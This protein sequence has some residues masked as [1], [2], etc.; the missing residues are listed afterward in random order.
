MMPDWGVE[1]QNST[2]WWVEYQAV[3]WWVEESTTHMQ[4]VRCCFTWSERRWR[5][6]VV[7]VDCHCYT[8]KSES[9]KTPDPAPD[10]K[11][12]PGQCLHLLKSLYGLKQAP[13]NWHLHFVKF[14]KTLGFVQSTLDNCL[15][16]MHKD[17]EMFLLT[18]YVDDILICASDLTLLDELKTAFTQNF[19]MKDL[20]EVNQYLGMHIT[21]T[22]QLILAQI[23]HM[24]WEYYQDFAKHLTIERV[25]H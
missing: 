11:L 17:G 24:Q 7:S 19:E 9:R 8:H 6:G 13:K 2:H 10:M 21:R 15:F 16:T 12:K 5:T 3:T 25:K 18:L 20:G 14:I 1:Y 22:C 23:L 4:P